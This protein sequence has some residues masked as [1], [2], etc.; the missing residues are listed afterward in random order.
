[1]DNNTLNDLMRILGRL[2]GKIDGIDEKLGE[3]SQRISDAAV[4]SKE[5]DKKVNTIEK[6]QYT[7]IAVATLAWGFVVDWIK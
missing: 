3:H 1:M 5:L 4:T 2:E 7:M 6:K